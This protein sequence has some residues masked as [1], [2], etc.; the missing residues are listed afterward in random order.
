MFACVCEAGL[1]S[2]ISDELELGIR[3]RL[4]ESIQHLLRPPGSVS[5]A[6]LCVPPPPD[7]RRGMS[8]K[9]IDQRVCHGDQS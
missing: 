5:L 1:A 3:N 9:I 7:G 2:A 6:S 8:T 4:R